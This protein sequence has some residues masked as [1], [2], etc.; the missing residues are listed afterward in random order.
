MPSESDT[1]NFIRSI[2][3][4]DIAMGKNDGRVATR[5]PPEPNGYLHIGHAK[6][7]VLNFGI[8]ALYGGRCN[9]RFDDTNPEKENSEYIASIKR[10]IT[11]L[12]YDWHE[13]RFASQHFERLYEY[14]E[15]LIE[16]GK[17]YV[18]DL[19]A[20]EIRRA[21]GTL[22]EPGRPSPWRRRGREENLALFRRMREGEFGDGEKVLRAKIDMAA[23]NLNL[24]DPV[25]YRIKHVRH[26][27]TGETWRIYP[28]YDYA[29][30][31]CDAIEGITHSLCT[32]EFEDHRPLYDWILDAL[33][34][35]CHPQ[36]IE[37]ARLQLEYTLTSK[38]GLRALIHKGAVDGWDDPRMPTL[39]GLRRRGAP[40]AAI[41]KFCDMVG[42]AK[43][44]S[45]IEMVT[46]ENCIRNELNESAPRRL[47]VL[48]PL[49]VVIE[50]YPADKTE[51]L[52]ARNHPQRPELG[53]RQIPFSREIYIERD[54]FMEDAP[55]R[56]FRLSPG[57]EVR[58]RFAY[59]ITCTGIVKD[60]AGRVA[61]LRCAY[62]PQTRG[63]GS[64]DGRKAKG[65]IH[66]VSARHAVEAQALLYERL[67]MSP[68]P[69]NRGYFLPDLNPN[70]LLV[71]EGCKVE[72]SLVKDGP[73][74]Y[75]FER[76]GYF[77]R[78]PA[79]KDKLVFGKIVSLRDSWEK[80]KAKR[81]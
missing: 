60:A 40:A 1:G 11:W 67:F 27:Q 13:L 4:A 28:M 20:E 29:H 75:Q 58:L 72:P 23:P 78:D 46:L 41:V 21:R 52:R 24:R 64:P 30:C 36:Q 77:Y 10:D 45:V 39:S 19:S 50:N 14:A 2:I 7:I 57:R 15:Q 79:A 18:D 47:A 48:N 38:R 49:K 55:K 69:A 44:N 62:D 66:W 3:E 68:N 51:M 25:L 43:N 61:E 32:L 70:S 8:A 73:G 56:F 74:R 42:V 34:T 33:Q 31:V 54:D 35:P 37:Y 80:A 26:H 5:F 22:T 63:G 81:G 9:L 76:N 53:E 6:S 65:T 16:K 17:A 59:Y 12:G 71:I